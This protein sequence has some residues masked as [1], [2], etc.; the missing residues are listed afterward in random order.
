VSGRLLSVNERE[1]VI[2]KSAIKLFAQKGYTSTS[3]QEI[4][5]ESGISKG[6]FYLSFKSKEALLVAILNYYS[7][8]MQDRMSQ[9]DH[10]DLPP[11]EKFINQLTVLLENLLEHKEFIIMHT[12]EQAIPVNDE[13][14][15]I[16]FNLHNRM[17]LFYHTNLLD[18]YG[19]KITPHLWDL[20]FILEGMFQSYIRVLFFH[21]EAF[22]PQDLSMFLFK[23]IDT[24]VKD[25][26]LSSE[27]PLLSDEKINQIKRSAQVFFDNE[28]RSIHSILAGMKQDLNDMEN[29]EDLEVSLEVLE[30]EIR[31]DSPRTAVIQ[32]MLSNFAPYP[33]FQEH[34][35]HIKKIYLKKI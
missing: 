35:S 2:I 13:V 30:N 6:A 16:I 34:I 23:K 1:K 17:H 12:R 18:I 7:Q 28:T 22:E 27:E 32:G 11:R 19:D 8:T 9:F 15:T 5:S 25:L 21:K 26:L 4:V 10:Q 24:I 33:K 20:S 14:K 3:V 29:K 31:S